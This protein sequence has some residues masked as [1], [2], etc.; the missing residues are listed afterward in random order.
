MTIAAHAN[1]DAYFLIRPF[2]FHKLGVT[3]AATASI[4][5]SAAFNCPAIPPC[6][7]SRVATKP[8]SEL[9]ERDS[10]LGQLWP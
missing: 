8:V 1:C 5:N 2:P 7:M 9:P 4:D 3:R 10:E 6:S